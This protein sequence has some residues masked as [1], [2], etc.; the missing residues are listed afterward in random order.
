MQLQIHVSQ[1]AYVSC[2]CYLRLTC[3]YLLAFYVV[4]MLS[5][6]RLRASLFSLVPAI[7]DE[8]MVYLLTNFYFP[9]HEVVTYN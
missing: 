3:T 5:L 1:H 8:S 4:F 7:G 6:K 2:T 9:I